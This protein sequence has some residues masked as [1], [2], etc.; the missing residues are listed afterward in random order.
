MQNA[1]N[2]LLDEEP[3]I[4]FPSTTLNY[5]VLSKKTKPPKNLCMSFTPL[6]TNKEISFSNTIMYPCITTEATLDTEK[7]M[8]HLEIE[9]SKQSLKK[10]SPASSRRRAGAI[11]DNT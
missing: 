5:G 9:K 11:C 2:I 8:S 3:I 4:Y 7:N 6:S 10:E 1:N